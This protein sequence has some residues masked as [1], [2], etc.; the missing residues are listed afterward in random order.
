MTSGLRN[1][2]VTSVGHNG[3]PAGPVAVTV[4][5]VTAPEDPMQGR[6][7]PLINRE[8]SQ[9]AF[10]LIAGRG[11]T[12]KINHILCLPTAAL[13]INQQLVESTSIGLG[14]W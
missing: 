13:R 5:R 11:L 10:N 3:Q 8:L 1:I 9:L 12:S 14:E 6:D 4:P 2:A 7:P